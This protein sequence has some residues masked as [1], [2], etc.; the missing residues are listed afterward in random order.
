MQTSNSAAKRLL[1][2]LKEKVRLAQHKAAMRRARR[3]NNGG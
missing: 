3:I 1:A 2:W